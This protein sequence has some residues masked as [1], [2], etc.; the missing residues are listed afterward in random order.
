MAVELDVHRLRSEMQAQA[1]S[2]KQLVERSG[3]SRAQLSRILSRKHG[4]V[5]DRT[6]SR[7][8][9]ALG[10]D[11]ADLIVDGR[12]Q[13]YRSWVVGEHG[14]V[15][16]QGIGMPQFQKQPIDD[17]FVE[18]DVIGRQ[19]EDDCAQ[20]GG[21]VRWRETQEPPIQAS[22]AI[23]KEDRIIVVGHPG[24]GKSTLLRWLAHQAASGT[25]PEVDTPIYLRLPDLSRAL[26]I[27]RDVDP[28]KFIGSMVA[29][30]GCADAEGFLRDRLA[31]EKLRSLVLLDGLDE[32]G[33][34]SQREQLVEAVGTFVEQ[35]P[36]NRFVLTS[37]LVGFDPAPWTDLGFSVVRLLGYGRTQL[38]E[39]AEKWVGILPKVFDRTAQE[40]RDSLENAIFSN[41][42]VRTLASNPLVL[43]ILVL[44]N[45]SRGGALPRRRVDLYA[46]IAEVFLDTWER[47]K[48]SSETFDETSDIDLDARELGWLL[49]DL[50]LAMQRNDRTLAARWWVADRIQDCLQNK[51]G[52]PPEEAKDVGDR[53]VR[54]LTE[55]AGLIEERGLDQFG[56]SHRTLQEFFAALG[57]IEEAD[58]SRTRDVCDGLKGFFYNP[59]WHEVVRLVAAKV[60]PPVAESTITSI[61]DDPD[62]VGRFL[63]RGPLLALG[64]LSDGATVPNRGLVSGIFDGLSELG[65]SKWLGITLEALDLLETFDGTRAE[66]MAKKTVTAILQTAEQ[67]LE[68]EE[69]ACLY[70]YAHRWSTVEK[71]KEHLPSDFESEA[72]S[73]VRID[74]AGNSVSVLLLNTPLRI[75]NPKVWF[76]SLCSLLQDDAK[77]T[78]F[79][80]LLV[81]QLA[82]RVATDPATRRAL[83]KLLQES[84]IAS[85][86][87]AACAS[88][89][90]VGAR[91][92]DARLLLRCLEREGED[93]EV[94][95]ACAAT[96]RDSAGSDESSRKKLL[97]ILRSDA[98]TPLRAAAA[99]GLGKAA[100]E[101]P[102]ITALLLDLASQADA[103]EE[104]RSGC[105][106]ALE[107]QIA[108]VAE[109]AGFF[110]TLLDAPAGTK[111]RRIAAQALGRAMADDER[112]WDHHMVEKIEH[113]LMNLTDPCPHA[114]RSL[115]SLATAREVRRGLRLESVIRNALMPFADRI[116][117]AFVFGST[118]RKRQTEDSDIDLL[119][120]GGVTLR[121]LS[122]PLRTAERTLGR[123]IS[124]AL[125]T[126]D[127]FQ[128]KYQTGDPFLIDV[129]RREKM[130]VM[131]PGA[132]RRDLEDELT[133]MVAERL[134]STG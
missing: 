115:K 48:R 109:V 53:I 98:P 102:T 38:K 130:A 119:V 26:E 117:L 97:D 6:I 20:T 18:P 56:F 95:S 118:A 30:R 96:L 21:R 128:Q 101:H 10:V 29:S 22:E 40:V 107:E 67:T 7:L 123:R 79:K 100:T 88:A 113:V 27:N 87:R 34:V 31:H 35:Y 106:W 24:N 41:R 42:R 91:R 126:H 134:A 81:R 71:L 23:L 60:T 84:A 15:D 59:N 89:L 3:V 16:F 75:E 36:R 83:R 103:P 108:H 45:E 124:P 122:T 105:A 77:T 85:S 121:D 50:A 1:L 129:Y 92:S 90:A 74:A 63:R 51:M 19:A 37:R 116:E 4:S 8:A 58:A 82:R 68:G 133:A 5:R 132:S 25:L 86:V 72:A 78:E 14:F 55:R 43:T 9:Q 112:L 49:S 73:E 52:F 70:Q 64:C 61:L 131:P 47:T 94:R 28:V 54:Y 69:Y 99:R 114:L 104:L 65:Q 44:L 76:E 110:R 39:F 127:T 13:R 17:I 125:Y 57:V 111:L 11:P 80:E 32:V 2:Q 33:D 66:A 46:K 12:L 93:I 62:P 120:I